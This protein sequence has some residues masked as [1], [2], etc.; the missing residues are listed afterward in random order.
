MVYNTQNY[1]VFWTLSIVRY[2]RKLK[3]TTLRELDLL[4]SSGEEGKTPTQLGP[5]ETVNL[6]LPCFFGVHRFSFYLSG[7]VCRGYV[8]KRVD[9]FRCF[10]DK[11]GQNGRSKVNI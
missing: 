7:I 6:N 8:H 3:D 11:S 1:S 4:P 2:Y 9:L 10:P 5:S